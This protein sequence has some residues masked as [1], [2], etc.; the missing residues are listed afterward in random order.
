VLGKDEGLHTSRKM[1]TARCLA[2]MGLL[3]HNVDD[4]KNEY[5]SQALTIWSRWFEKA[6]QDLKEEDKT[7][8]RGIIKIL[9]IPPDNE[10]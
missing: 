4:P 2:W 6:S 10:P 9:G 7:E 1:I 5:F 3:C 8:V